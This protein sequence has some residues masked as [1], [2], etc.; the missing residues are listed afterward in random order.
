MTLPKRRKKRRRLKKSVKR[1]LVLMA[2]LLVLAVLI[3]PCAKYIHR[4]K[5]KPGGTIRIDNFRDQNELHLKYA[6]KYGITPF[7]S[8]KDFLEKKEGLVSGGKLVRIGNSRYYSVNK[9]THSHPYLIPRASEL[10]DQIGRRFHQKLKE[11]GL[12]EYQFRISSLLRTGESQKQLRHVNGNAS[13]NSAH[14]YGT[15]FDI[16]YRSLVKKS[17]LGKSRVVHEADALRVLS[18]TIGELRKEKKLVVITEKNEACF[19]ITV[20]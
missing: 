18:E 13:P 3:P 2:T 6:R 14:L 19:H 9:L 7:N 20:R 12:D 16:P 15:T 17:L 1:V 10:L 4:Q 11:Q 8:G 5:E